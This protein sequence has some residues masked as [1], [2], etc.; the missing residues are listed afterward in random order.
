MPDGVFDLRQ[1]TNHFS[2]SIVGDDINLTDYC[3]G[4][5]ELSTFMYFIMRDVNQKLGIL[6]DLRNPEKHPTDFCEHFSTVQKMCTFEANQYEN[7]KLKSNSNATMGSR[8]LL[9]L[10]RAFLFIIDLFERVCSDPP[11]VTLSQLARTAY[12][13][14]LAKY[15][16]WAIQKACDLAFRALP[17]RQTF[18]SN[19]VAMQALDGDLTTE[20]T[21]RKYLIETSIPI[22]RKVYQITQDIYAQNDMLDLP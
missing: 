19:L 3:A 11:E 7:N 22:L 6:S 2:Q 9:R 5:K 10:H 21:C 1:M 15:H 18:I 8:N 14:S 16:P 4:Y 12:D 13:E 20:E 17:Y